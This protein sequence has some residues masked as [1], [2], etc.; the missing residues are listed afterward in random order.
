MRAFNPDDQ[1]ADVP[2]PGYKLIRWDG[3][4]LRFGDM[5]YSSMCGPWRLVR[6]GMN[7][8]GARL[9]ELSVL[10]VATPKAVTPIQVSAIDENRRFRAMATGGVWM[11]K[12]AGQV[13]FE[14][15]GHPAP[16]RIKAD[17]TVWLEEL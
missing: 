6:P 14:H 12:R 10:G 2:P 16:K 7:L 1:Y 5:V 11:V 3:Y 17:T 4:E 9:C 13:V 15:S 8:I